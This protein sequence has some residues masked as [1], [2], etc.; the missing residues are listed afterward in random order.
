[1]F[2]I[3]EIEK[4]ILKNNVIF[5]TSNVAPQ[6]E[7]EIIINNVELISDVHEFD[8]LENSKNTLNIFSRFST[9]N[10]ISKNI[11]F[12]KKRVD[13]NVDKRFEIMNKHFFSFV[14]FVFEL[15][16]TFII[17]RKFK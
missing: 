10:N 7:I 1:M 17:F 13:N 14:K 11:S 9:I 12:F 15:N 4:K 16:K 8:I 6:F 2:K 5:E 3:I